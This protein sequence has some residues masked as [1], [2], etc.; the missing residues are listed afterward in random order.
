MPS[1]HS[2]Q[3]APTAGHLKSASM[4]VQSALHPSPSLVLLSSH[5]SLGSRMPLP[6]LA[7][8]CPGTGQLQP[9]STEQSTAHPSAAMG[10]Q[11][12]PPEQA[13][14]VVQAAPS[15]LPPEHCPPSSQASLVSRTPFPHRSQETPSMEHVQGGPSAAHNALQPSPG[16]VLLSSHSSPVSTTPFPHSVQLPPPPAQLKP[17]SITLQSPRQPSLLF[18]LPSSQTSLPPTLPS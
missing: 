2:T 6:Q 13:P 14:S 17:A 4:V 7:Q 9:V 12:P 16:S 15:L 11:L 1:P 5:V 8:G 3:A 10:K 18:V